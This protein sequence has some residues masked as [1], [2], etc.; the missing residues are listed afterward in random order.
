MTFWMAPARADDHGFGAK[1]GRCQ[2]LVPWQARGRSKALRSRFEVSIKAG[3]IGLYGLR[4]TRY[5]ARKVRFG[6]NDMKLWMIF[7]VAAVGFSSTALGADKYSIAKGLAHV[8]GYSDLCG[9]KIDPAKIEQY[10]TAQGIDDPATLAT[11]TTNIQFDQ[12]DK[13]SSGECAIAKATAK[14]I[15]V[16]IN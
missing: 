5:Q 9:F 3:R 16:L 13:P 14:A 2:E 11:M 12:R 15:G 6:G 7:L 1:P 4:A 10:S 8:I